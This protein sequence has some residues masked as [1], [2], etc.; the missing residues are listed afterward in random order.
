[1]L[2][3][4]FDLDIFIPIYFEQFFQYSHTVH[5]KRGI[6]KVIINKL[7]AWNILEFVFRRTGHVFLLVTKTLHFVVDSNSI[8]TITANIRRTH[9]CTDWYTRLQCFDLYD[10]FL[11][12][13]YCTKHLLKASVT[14]NGTV[15]HQV[16]TEVVRKFSGSTGLGV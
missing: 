13:H 1:V 14:A 11:F 12:K 5:Y 7:A 2:G 10:L 3:C 16:Q 4:Y 6:F 15:S 8:R 9:K